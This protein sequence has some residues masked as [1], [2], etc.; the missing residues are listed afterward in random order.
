VSIEI[1]PIVHEE[2]ETFSLA[3]MS[4]F[5]WEL[6][7]THLAENEPLMEFD[8]TLAAFDGDEIVGTTAI[9]SFDVTTPGGVLP[10][11]GVTWV[12]VKPTHRRQGILR[13]V[14]ERQLNDVH[15]RAEP[16]AGLWASESVIY[17]RFGYGLAA[18]DVE[19]KI[20]R[21]RTGLARET[22][23]CGRLRLVSRE[24]ALE[25]WPAVYDQARTAR[26]G[27]C[28]RNEFWWRHHTLRGSDM[29][30][31]AGARFYVQHEEDG[32]VLGYARYRI[33]PEGGSE[34]ANGTLAVQE[35][36]AVTDQAYNALWQYIFGVDLIGSIQAEH[37]PLDEPLYWMLADPRRLVRRPYD[38]L[39]VRV[40]DVVPALEGRRYSATGR[41]VLDVR[42]PFC[43]WNEGRYE[44][45]TGAEGARCRRTDAE[46]DITL[47]AADLGAVYLGGTRLATLQRAGRV[48]GD[49]NAIRRAD[50]LFSWE[51]L[52]CCP[53]VF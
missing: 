44:L 7:P 25:A 18:Q 49:G 19:F 9:Q 26:P 4:A 38:S 46:P 27:Y 20:D 1:R 42:D 15:E 29:E 40:V 33:R 2:W 24:E 52:P 5:G 43:A 36:T 28:T 32:R 16:L 39:W 41:V 17:G 21:L 51:P 22:P 8:R 53:E 37:R 50:A 34:G 13:Q 30:R 31:R 23:S 45:E 47:S 35:L 14:M 3:N 11:A 48:E 10:M 6:N 12:S